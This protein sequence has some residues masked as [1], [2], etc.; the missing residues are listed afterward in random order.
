MALDRIIDVL[1]SYWAYLVLLILL[2]ASLNALIKYF[3]NQ[4]FG[5][6]DFRISLFGLIVT[7]IQVLIGFIL[8]F[9]HPA[10]GFASFTRDDLTMADIMGNSDLRLFAVE[11]PLV[12]LIAVV[13]ITIGYSKHKKQLTSKGKFKMLALFYTIALLLVLSRI[14]WGHWFAS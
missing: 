4:P 11:H 1:H 6:K 5:A 3:S 9:S 13:L 10:L 12:M 7:H 8:Y 2:L 14:P